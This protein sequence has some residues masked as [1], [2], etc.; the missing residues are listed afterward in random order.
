MGEDGVGPQQNEVV[1]EAGYADA[2]VGA[3]VLVKVI[4]E[5]GVFAANGL[6]AADA[7]LDVESRRVDDDVELI[8]VTVHRPDSLLRDL[9]DGIRVQMAVGLQ[10]DGQELVGE[11][12]TLAAQLVVWYDL[13]REIFVIV[14]EEE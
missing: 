9:R 1:G 10:E 14:D 4:P 6:E 3:R 13:L 8:M 5:Q 12:E 2:E 7:L 11:E